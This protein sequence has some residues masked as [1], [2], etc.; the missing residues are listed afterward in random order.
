MTRAE[1]SEWGGER[2]YVTQ[3][4]LTKY[5]TDVQTPIYFISGPVAMVK[6]LR[7]TLIEAQVEIDHIKTEIYSGY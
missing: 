3:E 1:A 7:Q 2:G 4:M 5:L 6:A